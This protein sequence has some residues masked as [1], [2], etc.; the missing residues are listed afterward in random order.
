MDPD[1][2]LTLNQVIT[3]DCRGLLGGICILMVTT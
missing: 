2:L 1:G 3:I